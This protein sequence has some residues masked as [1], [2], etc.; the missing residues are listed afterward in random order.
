MVRF[1]LVRVVVAC[2]LGAIEV[3]MMFKRPRIVPNCAHYSMSVL[4][5]RPQPRAAGDGYY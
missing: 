4:Y 2:Q 1:A 5:V 3:S